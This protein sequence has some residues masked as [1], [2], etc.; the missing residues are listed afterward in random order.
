MAVSESVNGYCSISEQRM[1]RSDCKDV[2]AN[3]GLRSTH[4][5]LGPFSHAA[6]QLS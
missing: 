5:A 1:F 3:L 6:H 4:M 2:H